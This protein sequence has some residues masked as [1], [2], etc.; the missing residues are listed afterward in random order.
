MPFRLSIELIK[1]LI[2][3]IDTQIKKEHTINKKIKL[4]N[5]IYY[6]NLIKL[7]DRILFINSKLKCF[8]EL[9]PTTE[10]IPE[11]KN[12]C[13][14][15]HAK[16][17]NINDIIKPIDIKHTELIKKRDEHYYKWYLPL[18]CINR[19]K[20]LNFIK[21][22]EELN[23]KILL[24]V[25]LLNNEFNDLTILMS[26]YEKQIMNL[27][28]KFIPLRKLWILNKWDKNANNDNQKVTISTFCQEI[29]SKDL[30][31]SNYKLHSHHYE[32]MNMFIKNMIVFDKTKEQINAIGLGRSCG[33]YFLDS[34]LI[35]SLTNLPSDKLKWTTLS[36]MVLYFSL[37][38]INKPTDDK[39]DTNIINKYNEEK[40]ILQL[41]NTDEE[42][43]KYKQR[44]LISKQQTLLGYMKEL[45]Q[46]QE[47][48]YK[49]LLH[50][51]KT[52]I[53]I[54]TLSNDEHIVMPIIDLVDI[55]NE[56]SNIKLPQETPVQT[57]EHSQEHLQEHSQEHLQEPQDDVSKNT[58][59][60]I[61][62]K[63]PIT[64]A[65]RTSTKKKLVVIPHKELNIEQIK[66]SRKKKNN[67]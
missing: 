65:K 28:F 40:N 5:D 47:D 39:V 52:T 18:F 56:S 51:L 33:T 4:E 30:S 58:R 55:S 35:A 67:K 25:Q 45:R 29:Q 61:S 19:Y 53:S 22:L 57:Q 46:K 54:N 36:D 12:R 60:I 11:L 26:D 62:T 34:S 21:D 43:N 48:D 63:R 13:E 9:S 44:A 41:Y 3:I 14:Q 23:K 2:I 17:H 20:K 59:S 50:K 1:S 24:H 8:Q 7:Y 27:K 31:E 32:K 49:S 10:E 64:N 66:T 6:D 38:P 16:I 42:Y 37:L 15:L